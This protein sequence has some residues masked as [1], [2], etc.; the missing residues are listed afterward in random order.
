MK[1]KFKLGDHVSNSINTRFGTVSYIHHKDDNLLYK[2]H[3]SNTP[4]EYEWFSEDDLSAV[5]VK[6]SFD[7]TNWASQQSKSTTDTQ[8]VYDDVK[9]IVDQS[10]CK[11]DAPEVTVPM[12]IRPEGRKYDSGKPRYSLLPPLALEEVVHVLTFG[13]Q[14]YEDFNWMKVENAND[15]Y[16]SAANRH[17]WQWKRGEMLDDETKRHHLASAI[18]NLMF[19]LEMELNDSHGTNQS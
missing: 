12:E 8:V 13:S 15:R 16:F 10:N 11:V 17:L 6:E 4:Y 14:K 18:T 3:F 7:S 1:Y 5:I 19:I 2:V 9:V